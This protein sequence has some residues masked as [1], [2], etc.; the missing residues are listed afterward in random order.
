MTGSAI[1]RRLMLALFAVTVVPILGWSVVVDLAEHVAFTHDRG[2]L[3]AV[4]VYAA[5]GKAKLRLLFVLGL[6]L[7]TFALVLLYL[8]RVLVA[9]LES[10]ADRARNASVTWQTPP[11]HARND[12]IGDLARA[13]DSSV[14]ELADRVERARRFSADLS[15]EL[16]TPLAAIQGAAEL[17]SQEDVSPLDAR[18]FNQNILRESQRLGRL[19]EGILELE[20]GT[21]LARR[22]DE[23][24]ELA[25]SIRHVAEG[26]SLLATRKGLELELAIAEEPAW[27]GVDADR[28]NRVLFALLENALKYSPPQ[29]RIEIGLSREADGFRI[30]VAD[31]GPGVAD[32]DRER[33]FERRVHGED[34]GSERGTGLG[35][36]IAKALVQSWG[37][38]IRVDARPGG[39]SRFEY[40]IPALAPRELLAQ[41][42]Q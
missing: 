20:R 22:N 36:A 1:S 7:T 38:T 9:P 6:S 40:D 17:L 25:A 27:A 2:L 31:R 23:G 15:H 14:R 30:S 29:Q 21:A 41:E 37:G 26:L 18:R 24:C 5:I 12:E 11:E 8:R 39:G 33:I 13:L 35:L 28:H 3:S 4:D 19:V 10:L 16:R 42:Q 34:A 32:A